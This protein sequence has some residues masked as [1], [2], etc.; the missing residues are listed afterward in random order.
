M[1]RNRSRI[2]QE[3]HNF[4]FIF[5]HTT[6]QNR[7]LEWTKFGWLS[8]IHIALYRNRPYSSS[9]SLLV[10]IVRLLSTVIVWWQLQQ[11]ANVG[12]IHTDPKSTKHFTESMQCKN[13]FETLSLL[14]STT[15]IICCYW[16]CYRCFI[17]VHFTFVTVSVVVSRQ[18]EDENL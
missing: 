3:W 7:K 12:C 4:Y 2:V 9:Y 13:G 8:R 17:V 11:W 14:R 5:N 1:S 16:C 15:G 10:N 6:F 18:S